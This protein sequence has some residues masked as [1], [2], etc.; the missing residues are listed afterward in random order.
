MDLF[1]L[2]KYTNK[3]IAELTGLGQNVVKRIDLKRLREKYTID[4]EHL[5]KPTKTAKILGIDEFK[6]HNGRK[7]ATHIIDME[8]GHILW[9]ANEKQN[10]LCMISSSMSVWNGWILSRL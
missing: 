3:S 4:G 5:K 2:G 6:L 1:A 10:R 9:I 7:Y 8:T